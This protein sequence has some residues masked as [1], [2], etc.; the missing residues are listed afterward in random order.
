MAHHSSSEAVSGA[1]RIE[2]LRCGEGRHDIHFML[3]EEHRPVLAL[4]DHDKL[5]AHLTDRMAGPH[6]VLVLCEKLGLGVVQYQAIDSLEQLKLVSLNVDPEVHRVGDGQGR[7]GHLV[8][9]REL[10]DR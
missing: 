3:T 10:G 7:V 5:R 4:F 9:H 2:H 8:E 6:K 1:C